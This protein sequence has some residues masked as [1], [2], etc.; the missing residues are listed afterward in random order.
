[1][2]IQALINTLSRSAR[3]ARSGYHLTLGKLIAALEA[4]PQDA[5]VKL[6]VG[7][8]PSDP[9]SYRGYY[10]DLSFESD[11]GEPPTVAAFLAT[12]RDVHG[13]TLTGYKGGDFLMGDDAVLWVARYG[14]SSGLAMTGAS[15]SD[16]AFTIATKQVED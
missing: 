9:H 2:A 7:G 5:V 11:E 3:Q 12:C 6:D 13:R 16:G 10:E 4:A 14:Q 15:V 1:M 8:F